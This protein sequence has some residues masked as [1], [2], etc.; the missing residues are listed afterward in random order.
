MAMKIYD[1]KELSKAWQTETG[2]AWGFAV[3][4]DTGQF[5]LA[6]D[7]PYRAVTLG[8]LL[9]CHMDI[10]SVRGDETKW[11]ERGWKVFDRRLCAMVARELERE[12]RIGKERAFGDEIPIPTDTEIE[13]IY[14]K[15]SIPH[16]I[17]DVK[18]VFNECVEVGDDGEVI[19]RRAKSIEDFWEEGR[20]LVYSDW[21]RRRNISR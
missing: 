13:E 15:Y 19:D 10:P 7:R 21:Q 11:G 16:F 8:T 14:A 2:M 6:T 17:D 1:M 4:T 18:S 5:M 12:R 20:F 9:M 3:E